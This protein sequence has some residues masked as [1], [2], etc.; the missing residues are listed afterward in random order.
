MGILRK[1]VVWS[2]CEASFDFYLAL[3]AFGA[4]SLLRIEMI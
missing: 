4:G 1:A 2:A 3:D